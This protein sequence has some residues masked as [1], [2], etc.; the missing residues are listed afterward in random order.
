M[1]CAAWEFLPETP[2]G[3]LG[4]RARSGLASLGAPR[5]QCSQWVGASGSAPPG[6][7]GSVLAGPGRAGPGG[8]QFPPGLR[9][10]RWG[11]GF[12]SPEPWLGPGRAGEPGNIGGGSSFPWQQHAR[13][14]L[15]HAGS[16]RGGDG[17]VR[18]AGPVRDRVLPVASPPTRRRPWCSPRRKRLLDT[19]GSRVQLWLRVSPVRLSPAAPPPSL[20]T[21]W[22]NVSSEAPGPT[23]KLSKSRRAASSRPPFGLCPAAVWGSSALRRPRPPRPCPCAQSP[24]VSLPPH[25]SLLGLPGP[26]RVSPAKGT[27]PAQPTGC[28]DPLE[29]KV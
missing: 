26:Y 16:G 1:R 2:R 28:A 9:W 20:E 25:S 19:P 11:P 17:G 21:G 10:L 22:S 7:L 23:S 24:R 14:G 6:S 18:A 15:S 12:Q 13:P 8:A 4:I 29:S 5:G 3:E 27:I